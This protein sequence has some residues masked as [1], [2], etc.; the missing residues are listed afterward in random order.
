MINCKT[1]FKIIG[2]LLFI[3]SALMTCC[4]I[5][6][7]AFRENDIKPFSYSILITLVSALTLRLLG[8]HADNSM[9]R[10]DA[11]L[12]VSLSWIIFSFFGT[13]PFTIGGYVPSFTDAYFETM[14]GF[15]TTGATIISNVEILP[16]GILFW[17]SMTHWIGGLGIVFFTIAILPSFVGGSVKVFAA[18]ATG[19]IHSRLHPRLST[20]AK[21]IWTVYLVLTVACSVSFMTC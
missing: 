3:E 9:S 14:S 21:W 18:E 8:L 16:H 10:R 5:M 4:L 12:V 2:S 7:I 13:F 1:I 15:T 11:Y 19:P 17:R 20:S 6:A